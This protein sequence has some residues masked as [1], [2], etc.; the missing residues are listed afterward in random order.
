[1]GR[2]ASSAKT[3][4]LDSSVRAHPHA[5]AVYEVI[6]LDAGGFGVKVSI[7]ESSPTT[8]SSFDTEAAAETWIASHKSRVQ[9]QSNRVWYPRKSKA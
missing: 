1:M 5:E 4:S 3:S 7:P 2:S 6:R 8:V 9:A